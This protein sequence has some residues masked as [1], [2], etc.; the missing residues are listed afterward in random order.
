MMMSDKMWIEPLHGRPQPIFRQSRHAI[1]LA[2]DTP[3]LALGVVQMLQAAGMRV[4]G[5]FGS[6][7]G[8]LEAVDKTRLC[9][10]ILDWH[11]T[12][13]TSDAVA[14]RLAA[15]G[16]PFVFYTAA[17]GAVR[18]LWPGKAVIGKG[19]L[20]TLRSAIEDVAGRGCLCPIRAPG[21]SAVEPFVV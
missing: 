5:P 7:I 12:D 10:A 11:L 3:L 9:G 16:I 2:E 21:R 18:Q 8:A 4:V 6:R 13:G 20:D 15:Q 19:R 1:L 17:P 14:D